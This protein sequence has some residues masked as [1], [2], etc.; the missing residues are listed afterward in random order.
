MSVEKEKE[1]LYFHNYSENELSLLLTDLAKNESLNVNTLLRNFES[2]E[3]LKQKNIKKGKKISGKAQIIIEQN[4]KSNLNKLVDEDIT[5]LDYYKDI[6]L[7]DND[8]VGDIGLFKTDYGKNR[9]KYK[10]LEKAYKSE[11]LESTLEL[12]YIK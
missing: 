3:A 7:I 2:E 1:K 4:K 11:N 9:I 12:L 8:I 10:L 5:K 6:S